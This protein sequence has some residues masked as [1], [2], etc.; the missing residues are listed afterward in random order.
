M[1]LTDLAGFPLIV[2]IGWLLSSKFENIGCLH[3]AENTKWRRLVLWNHKNYK[4]KSK[5]Q[6]TPSKYIRLQKAQN[7]FRK[8]FNFLL[9]ILEGTPLLSKSQQSIKSKYFRN[10][11]KTNIISIDA[12]DLKIEFVD[13]KYLNGFFLENFSDN[14]YQDL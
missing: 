2:F 14:E 10:D 3:C 13:S 12:L 4:K 9:K 6:A 8:T 7:N 11:L 5:Y 1:E